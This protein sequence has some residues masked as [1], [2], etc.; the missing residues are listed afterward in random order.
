MRADPVERPDMRRAREARPVRRRVEQEPGVLD[1]RQVGPKPADLIDQAAAVH[2]RGWRRPK[3]RG[4]GRFRVGGQRVD[5]DRADR[6]LPG[7]DPSPTRSRQS[8]TTTSASGRLRLEQTPR[9]RLA[10]QQIVG[11]EKDDPFSAGLRDGAI[12]RRRETPVR[13]GNDMHARAE[14]ARKRKRA[15]GRAVVDDHDF[16][17]DPALRQRAR[18]PAPTVAAALKQGITIEIER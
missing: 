9:Q 6:P 4:A 16:A 1:D 2:Q 18:D 3:P 10:K 13:P 11:I 17:A 12:A 8:Q 14:T 7:S 15:V 5:I